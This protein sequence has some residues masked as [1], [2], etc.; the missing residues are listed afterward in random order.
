MKN[1]GKMMKNLQAMQDKM[2]QEIDAVEVEGS[3]GGGVVT[4]GGAASEAPA[5]PRSSIAPWPRMV[6]RSTCDSLL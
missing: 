1:I 5:S 6:A 4:A 2:Q 3:S